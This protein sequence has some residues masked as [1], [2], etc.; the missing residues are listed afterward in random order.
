MVNPINIPL[1]SSESAIYQSPPTVT[2]TS[3]LISD[4]NLLRCTRHICRDVSLLADSLGISSKDVEEIKRDYREVETQAYW[5]LKKWQETPSSNACQDQLY[6]VL[7][8]LGHHKAA[9][10]YLCLL[11]V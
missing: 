5:V 2:P 8:N 1:A 7:K 9:A 4:I 6:D 3:N 10:R 11:H